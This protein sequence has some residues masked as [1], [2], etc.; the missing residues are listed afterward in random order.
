MVTPKAAIESVIALRVRNRCAQ[1]LLR[2][3]AT[4]RLRDTAAGIEDAYIAWIRRYLVFHTLRHPVAMGEAEI[5]EF[6]A[7]LAVECRLSAAMQHQAVA[8]LCFL[9]H[10]VLGKH[11]PWLEAA[12][13]SP[14]DTTAP[15][16]V[17]TRQDDRAAC[18]EARPASRWH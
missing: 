4:L 16:R 18:A 11:V 17:A 1:L 2:V 9:Y 3:R 6:L 13:R 12:A 14:R 15:A 10:E 7:H 8:A 5:K